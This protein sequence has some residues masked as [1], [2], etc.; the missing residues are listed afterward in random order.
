LHRRIYSSRTLTAWLAVFITCEI[1]IVYFFI[2]ALAAHH[3]RA[4]GGVII[5]DAIFA[6][7]VLLMVR[8]LAKTFGYRYETDG[9]TWVRRFGQGVE[10]RVTKN[11]ITSIRRHGLDVVLVADDQE[12]PITR[13]CWGYEKLRDIAEEWAK[14]MEQKSL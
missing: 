8:D 13:D 4:A 14:T 1:G 12:L 10:Q 5:L 9:A 3:R 11:T 2:M 6:V 7:G